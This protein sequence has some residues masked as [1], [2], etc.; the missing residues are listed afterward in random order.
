[1]KNTKLFIKFPKELTDKCFMVR[2]Y[3]NLTFLLLAI[4]LKTHQDMAI[5]FEQENSKVLLN[6]Y[7][8]NVILKLNG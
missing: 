1:M 3:K 4:N 8:A 6:I 5:K 7:E 2:L